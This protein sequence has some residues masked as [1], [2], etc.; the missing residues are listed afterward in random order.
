MW[1]GEMSEEKRLER[2]WV[3]TFID[4]RSRDIHQ[5]GCGL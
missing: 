5:V 3:L 1:V 2:L 4:L